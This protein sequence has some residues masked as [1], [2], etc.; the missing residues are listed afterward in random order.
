MVRSLKLEEWPEP[1]RLAW[2]AACRPG[3]R[4]SRGGRA[5]HLKPVTRD[6]L[7]KRYGYFLDFLAR[8]GKLDHARSAT[9]MIEP[10]TLAAYIEELRARVGTVTVHGSIAKLRRAAELI[11]PALALGWLSEIECDLADAMRPRPKAHR[12]VLSD[13]IVAA[14]LALMERAETQAPRTS[15]Q[16]AQDARDGLMIALLAVCPIRLKNFHSLTIGKSFVRERNQWWIIL[17]AADTKSRRLDH[18]AVPA[19]LTPFIDR[20]VEHHRPVYLPDGDALWPARHGGAMTYLSVE[21]R[22]T[23]VTRRMLGKPINPHLF[24]HCVPHTIAHADGARIALASAVLQHA[25][26]RTTELHYNLQS[27]IGASRTL[28][29][30]VSELAAEPDEAK[31]RK[32]AEP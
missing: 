12:L 1:D 30:V 25:D 3:L 9:E 13:R 26:P 17:P 8:R 7:A 16:R 14:G 11:N 19:A 18:R 23:T 31:A 6:D 27:S 32:G 21:A 2:D 24:R 29:R 5:S 10:A 15:L 22:I 28:A 4:L 20:Y